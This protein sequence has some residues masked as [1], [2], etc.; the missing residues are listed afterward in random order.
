[1]F[2]PYTPRVNLNFYDLRKRRHVLIYLPDHVIQ[3]RVMLNFMFRYTLEQRHQLWYTS[4]GICKTKLVI[5]NHFKISTN[6]VVFTARTLV[7]LITLL[8]LYLIYFLKT[9]Y[10]CPLAILWNFCSNFPIGTL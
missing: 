4:Y 10:L 9:K 2:S 7:P 5:N 6:V 3:L 1:M 8:L